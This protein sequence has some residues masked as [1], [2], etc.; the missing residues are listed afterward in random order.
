MYVLRIGDSK[1]LEQFQLDVTHFSCYRI[2][3]FEA[4]KASSSLRGIERAIFINEIKTSISLMTSSDLCVYLLFSQSPV[5][6]P[7]LK[8][9]MAGDEHGTYR[10][11]HV[12]SPAGCL[13]CAT[14]IV[15][16]RQRTSLLAYYLNYDMSELHYCPKG[17]R[18]N[19]FN[20]ISIYTF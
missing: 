19:Y 1:L 6:K 14:D 10:P 5:K 15:R 11:V 20:R 3:N 9:S 16:Q 4:A 12:R 7:P 18:F 13:K 2:S 8:Q 17:K